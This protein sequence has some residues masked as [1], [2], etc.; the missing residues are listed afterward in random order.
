MSDIQFKSC[1]SSNYMSGRASKILYIVEHYTANNGDTAKDNA[2]YYARTP[3]LEASAHYYVDENNTIWQSVA[4]DDTSWHCGAK[5]YMHPICRN[6][7]SIGIEMCS[8]KDS[9][10]EY[11]I[12]DEV[13]A[14]AVR[15][16]V[17]LMKKYNIPLENV[18]RHYDVMGKLC[19][20]PF[21]KNPAQWSAFKLKISYEMGGIT[22]EQYEELKGMIQSLDERLKKQENVMKY[23]WI[24]DNMPEWA[25]P[26]I[27]KL[28]NRGILKG[29][30][31]D[32]GLDLSYSD[33]RIY[34]ALDRAG[35]FDK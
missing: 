25:R 13:Q 23:A 29:S 16:T 5:I 19:P 26:T 6:A 14:N 1:H 2:D 28:Y 9:N 7:N 4:D 24:D 31:E 34:V 17:E 30:G 20:L 8:R 3:N 11:Y 27:T 33:L 35:I 10:G 21:V 22:M 32:T 18:I 12:K 15:L